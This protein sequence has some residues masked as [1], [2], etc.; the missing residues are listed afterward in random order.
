MTAFATSSTDPIL[1]KGI[2]DA[3]LFL[4]PEYS[5][6]LIPVYLYRFVS[7]V[8]GLT[9]LTLIPSGA[10]S[11]AVHLVNISNPAFVIQYPM[12]PALGLL[13]YELEI[14]IMHPLLSAKC[15]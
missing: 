8:E 10:N 14:L 3:A 2:Q 13:P 9:A 15:G 11:N 12:V 1:Y 4:N 6:S 5:S 7:T